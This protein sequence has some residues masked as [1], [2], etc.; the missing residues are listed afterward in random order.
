MLAFLVHFAL[1]ATSL[2]A[3]PQA[4]HD[5]A[6]M[7]LGRAYEAEKD[8]RYAVAAQEFQAALALN[9]RLVR[10]R[11]Q[12]AVCLL[13]LGKT[14]E[15]GQEL[16]RLQ[17]ETG[18]DATISYQLAQIDLREGDAKSAVARLTPLMTAPPFQDTAYYLGIAYLQAGQLAPAEKWLRVAT[19]N[20]PL[21]YRVSE[22]LGRV[23]QREGRKAEAE[24]QFE[25]SAQLREQYDQASRQA[26]VCGQVL[27]SKPL[28]EAKPVCEQLFD[29]LDPE[30]LTTLGLLYGRH[31]L[32]ADALPPLEKAYQLDA[33]SFE[34]NHDLG[35]SYF[36][37][38]RYAKARQPLEN[39]VALR[40]DFYDSNAL[41]GATLFMLGEDGAAYQILL[42]AHAL[43]PGDASTADLLFKEAVIMA[44][45]EETQKNYA[46]A[47]AYLRTAGNLRPG[48]A[49]IQHRILELTTRSGQST[50]TLPH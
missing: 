1:T 26:Q 33:G 31:G 5:T 10:A 28:A 13:S 29:P 38:E 17:K 11:Y 49:G 30:R 43:S 4:P 18:G 34:I 36:R 21:D 7:H 45:R 41:L 14:H 42:H 9:P 22:H 32:Y 50:R 16:E 23:Y 3:R 25:L 20:D 46:S 39:A 8:D 24:K 27:D 2:L 48:D 12:L 44:D 47:L 15:A 19:R 6:E 37:L 40:P 35:L